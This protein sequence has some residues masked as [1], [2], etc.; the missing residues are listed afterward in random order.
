M[1]TLER[2]ALV[3]YSAAQMY[4]LVNDVDAYS[5][6]LPWC[7][8][9]QTLERGS[10]Y[11]VA[12]VDIKKGPISQHFT[13]RNQVVEPETIVMSLVD[14]PFKSL[15]GQWRFRE[16]DNLGCKVSFSIDFAF[17]NFLLEKTLSPVFS[18]IC[19]RMVDAFVARAKE[20]YR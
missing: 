17:S 3:T 2:S 8:G 1:A 5:D 16:I 20:V 7:A 6:F 11:Y 13:T 14:G 18:E 15:N 19:T 12:R 10:D 9:S 4:A